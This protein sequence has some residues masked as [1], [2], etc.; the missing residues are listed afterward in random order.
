[1]TSSSSN[2]IPSFRAT[3]W[4]HPASLSGVRSPATSGSVSRPAVGASFVPGPPLVPGHS[5]SLFT[6]GSQTSVSRFQPVFHQD[7]VTES[8]ADHCSSTLSPAGA[9]TI[10]VAQSAGSPVVAVAPVHPYLYGNVSA[11]AGTPADG[12]QGQGHSPSVFPVVIGLENGQVWLYEWQ[13]AAQE[14]SNQGPFEGFSHAAPKCVAQHLLCRQMA[15]PLTISVAR[16]RQATADQDSIDEE[17]KQDNFEVY[18]LYSNGM[19]VVWRKGRR[20][21]IEL[22]PV[23]G[24]IHMSVDSEGRYVAVSSSTRKLVVFQRKES[25]FGD[26]TMTFTKCFDQEVFRKQLNSACATGVPLQTAWHPDGTCLFLP[27]ASSVRV[28]KTATMTLEHLEFASAGFDPLIVFDKVAVVGLNF[29]SPASSQGE[30]CSVVLLASVKTSLRAW[31]L[32]DKQLLFCVEADKASASSADRL[33]QLAAWPSWHFQKKDEGQKA[34]SPFI[35]VGLARDDGAVSVVGIRS[36]TLAKLSEKRGR[37]A[38]DGDSGLEQM[39]L[40]QEHRD[41]QDGDDVVMADAEG[42]QEEQLEG[43]S[44]PE[45]KERCSTYLSPSQDDRVHSQ[46]EENCTSSHL[47]AKELPASSRD[48]KAQK[49]ERLETEEKRTPQGNE[50][51]T[52]A[53]FFGDRGVTPGTP[54]KRRHSVDG[55]TEA[56]SQSARAGSSLRRHEGEKKK[57]KRRKERKNAAVSTPVRRFIEMQAE[58]GSEEGSDQ[59]GELFG[60]GPGSGLEDE[61]GSDHRGE[62]ERGKR[63]REGSSRRRDEKKKRQRPAADSQ[64]EGG[65][66]GYASSG[67]QTDSALSGSSGAEDVSSDEGEDNS[68]EEESENLLEDEEETSTHAFVSGASFLSRDT[69]GGAAEG[70]DKEALLENMRKLILQMHAKQKASRQEQQETKRRAQRLRTE[71]AKLQRELRRLRKAHQ[72]M[73]TRDAWTSGAD[74]IWTV[75]R[76]VSPGACRQPGDAATPW[77]LFWNQHGHVTKVTSGDKTTLEI[78]NFSPVAAISGTSRKRIT[79]Y[80]NASMAALSKV[81]VAL[82]SVGSRRPLLPSRVEFRSLQDSSQWTKTLPVPERPLGVAIGDSFVAVVTSGDLLRIFAT[83][84]I[85]LSL[86]RLPGVPV[87]ICASHQLLFVVCATTAAALGRTSEH[88]SRQQDR[89]SSGQDGC[90]RFFFHCLLLHIHPAPAS[91]SSPYL[92]PFGCRDRVAQ[93]PGLMAKAFPPIDVIHEGP[94]VLDQPLDWVNIS[95]GGMPSV[96]DTSGRVWGLLPAWGRAVEGPVPYSLSWLPLVNLYEAAGGSLQDDSPPPAVK[97][98][99]LYVDESKG[100]IMVIRL[101]TSKESGSPSRD[102][103]G[104]ESLSRETSEPS[105]RSSWRSGPPEEPSCSQVSPLFGYTLEQLPLRLPFTDV[106]PYMRWRQLLLKDKNLKGIVTQPAGKNGDSAALTMGEA[107]LVPWHQ[108]DEMR[109][110]NEVVMRLMCIALK[111]WEGGGA[112]GGA[113]GPENQQDVLKMEQSREGAEAE[114][115]FTTLMKNHDKFAMREFLVCREDRRLHPAALDVALRFKM[116]TVAAHARNS[117]DGD[118]RMQSEK[119][120]EALE[121]QETEGRLDGASGLFSASQ[122]PP[123]DSENSLSSRRMRAEVENRQPG[124]F[125]GVGSKCSAGEGSEDPTETPEGRRIEAGHQSVS[126]KASSRKLHGV[127]EAPAAKPWMRGGNRGPGHQKFSAFRQAAD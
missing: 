18:V 88:R 20:N 12:G 22:G 1:M 89:F 64:E 105:S 33:L 123:V 44:S 112:G 31:L 126:S 52:R 125:Y 84:G 36:E 109:W 113:G 24:G 122:L 2:G 43:M 111:N 108:F 87:G 26:D 19:V 21:R 97:F 71:N 4:H 100:E 48:R 16:F 38:F 8:S 35:E 14:P 29:P 53:E 73:L 17:A 117:L 86:S 60:D 121:W 34:F 124:V 115:R 90:K 76:A 66:D 51:K 72:A 62:R 7:G 107:A 77:C 55:E 45:M 114:K 10:A 50:E 39:E 120:R 23:E 98:W 68:S 116:P 78:F 85:A 57:E 41:K 25:E 70:D 13:Q 79:D 74:A 91:P 49:G 81:G 103:D 95:T 104:Q 118:T 46:V 58:E 63:K 65:D 6:Y 119:L 92:L 5:C 69:D 101:K 42:Q 75:E 127:M 54:E 27:G 37:N 28:L 30:R 56:S 93:L 47:K 67:S 59:D 32:E 94:L 9:A 102:S 40:K 110:R 82:A 3:S 96:K 106:W 61:A 83:S 80:T 15:R 99:P 11:E